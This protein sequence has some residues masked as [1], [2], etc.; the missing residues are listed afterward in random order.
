MMLL[1]DQEWFTEQ[2]RNVHY[3]ISEIVIKMSLPGEK[4]NQ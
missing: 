2:N 3:K 4:F 1:C